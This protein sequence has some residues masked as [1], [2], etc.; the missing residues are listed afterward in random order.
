MPGNERMEKEWEKIYI[1]EIYIVHFNFSLSF[2]FILYLENI[3]IQN[4]FF[5]STG[6][7]S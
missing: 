3:E 2:S 7:K 6:D 4:Y 1:G 5:A